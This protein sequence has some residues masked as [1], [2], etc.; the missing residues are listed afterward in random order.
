MSRCLSQPISKAPRREWTAHLIDLFLVPIFEAPGTIVERAAGALG[1]DLN[2]LLAA[3]H[4]GGSWR[5][6]AP[7]NS[8]TRALEKKSALVTFPAQPYTWWQVVPFSL[9]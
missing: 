8:A 9:S 4:G 2:R 3:L 7:T 6:A 5:V 1:L